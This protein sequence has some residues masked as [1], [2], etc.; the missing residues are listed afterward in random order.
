[1]QLH[2]KLMLRQL[3][4][5]VLDRW[6]T[7]MFPWTGWELK[8]Y[9]M[10]TVSLLCIL[11][12]T[13]IC[14]LISLC[15]LILARTYFHLTYVLAHSLSWLDALLIAIFS[16]SWCTLVKWYYQGYLA[17]AL[18]FEY[19]LSVI[20]IDA[21]MHHSSVTAAR[22]ERIRKHYAAK[23]RKSECGLYHLLIYYAI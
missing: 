17:Q 5:L 19:Q 1:M 18:S 6:E 2:V 16:G 10:H 3:L 11:M 22:A 8:Y 4:M 7:N 20:A 14:D 9:H 12:L 23:L 15:D 21:S 13:F